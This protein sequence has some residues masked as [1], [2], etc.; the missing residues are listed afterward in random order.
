M[1]VE[2]PAPP[3]PLIPEALISSIS[4]AWLMD[5]SAFRT[6]PYPPPAR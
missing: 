4:S 3:R 5:F 2:N 6:A 1:P